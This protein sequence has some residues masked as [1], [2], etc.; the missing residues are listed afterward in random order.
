MSTWKTEEGLNGI[1][2]SYVRNRLQP[3][4]ISP[5]TSKPP[6]AS[7]IKVDH[8]GNKRCMSTKFSIYCL[9]HLLCIIIIWVPWSSLEKVF[10]RWGQTETKLWVFATW[11]SHSNPCSFCLPAKRQNEARPLDWPNCACVA[12]GIPG[13]VRTR[14]DAAICNLNIYSEISRGIYSSQSAKVSFWCIF[15]HEQSIL[16]PVLFSSVKKLDLD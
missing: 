10:Q 11:I 3:G 16:N 13:N 9:S 4:S 2:S 5:P 12:Q 6:P 8:A 14:R 1:G 15:E 7:V